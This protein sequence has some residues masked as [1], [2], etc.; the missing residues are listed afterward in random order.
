MAKLDF[1][2]LSVEYDEKK[3]SKSS[4][5]KNRAIEIIGALCIFIGVIVVGFISTLIGI[6]HGFWIFLFDLISIFLV[7]DGGL[8][9]LCKIQQKVSPRHF[10][11]VTWLMRFKHN[12]IEVG[13][14]NDRFVVELWNGRGGWMKYALQKF[15]G[16]DYVL[17]DNS[18]KTKTIF[19]TVDLMT[20]PPR[21]SITNNN[22]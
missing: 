16:C 9:L 10:D 15:I 11:L 3:I 21:I 18:D 1:K 5:R 13:W 20:D 2:N 6:E 22:R 8:F 17:V 12:E 4:I 14:L 19:M 7:F